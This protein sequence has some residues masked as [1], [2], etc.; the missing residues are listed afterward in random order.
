[1]S[2]GE[3]FSHTFQ[4]TIRSSSIAIYG[5]T[6][7]CLMQ[8]SDEIKPIFK[9]KKRDKTKNKQPQNKVLLNIMTRCQPL[10]MSVLLRQLDNAEHS[11]SKPILS[12]RI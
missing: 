2:I 3:S 6:L 10:A 7:V 9:K 1:M 12:Q 4:W 5:S 11:F 8:H